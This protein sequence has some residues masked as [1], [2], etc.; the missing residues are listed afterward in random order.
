MFRTENSGED[1]VRRRSKNWKKNGIGKVDKKGH[2][3][4]WHKRKRR[5][6]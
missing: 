3:M 6:S 5:A 4:R 1:V 2:K